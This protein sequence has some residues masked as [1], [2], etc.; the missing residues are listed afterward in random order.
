VAK[1]HAHRFRD[2]FAVELLLVSTP[3]EEVS[4]LLGHHSI[5]ITERHYS[6]W[7]LARQKQL[8]A[9]LE[10]AWSQDPIVLLLQA[11]GTQEV[12]GKKEAVN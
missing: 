2:T 11:K 12:H 3:I 6:P 9:H 7:V 4:V 10:R 1:G 8:E 5:K